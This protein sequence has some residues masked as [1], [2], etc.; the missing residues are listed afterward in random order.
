MSVREFTGQAVA[1]ALA[2]NWIGLPAIQAQTEV[3][4]Q[5]VTRVAEE[6]LSDWAYFAEIKLPEK[7]ESK[8]VDFLLAPH[9]FAGARTD[10]QD[11]RV[12]TADGKEVPFALRVRNDKDRKE[13]FEA[14]ELNRTQGPQGSSELTL[15]LLR[16]N[17]RHNELELELPGDEYRRKV[18]LEGSDDGSTWKPIH[19][20][21]AVSFERGD[22]LL[23]DK[24]IPYPPSRYRYL[25]IRVFQDPLVDEK[26]VRIGKV[27][28]I[29]RVQV[30]GE[31]QELQARIGRLEKG[32]DRGEYSSSWILHLQADRSPATR[33]EATIE[34]RDFVR[35]YRIEAGGLEGSNQKFRNIATGI[36]RRR[37]DDAVEPMVS[38]FNETRAARLRLTVIDNR[39]QPLRIKRVMYAAPARQIVIAAPPSGQ[40]LRLYY[41]NPE[42][43][44]PRYDFAR[45]LP[46]QL[47]PQPNRAQLGN[48][49]ENP[50]FVPAPL[51]LTERLPW[52]IYVVLGIAILVLGA[53]LANLSRAA[54]RAHDLAAATAE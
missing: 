51:P 46:D 27:A 9:V 11:L 36:W 5:E 38:R 24:S 19:N 47:D 28:V 18:E 7:I 20:Q 43:E 17:A 48:Q 33:L 25:R 22:V 14:R 2:C 6:Q 34:D 54:I 37:A 3:A 29:R 12:Y 21:F 39:N 42:A 8:W 45:N 16:S 32:R 15:D 53:I 1:L 52:L 41:G 4:S 49:V 35:N 30:P 23:R 44:N 50:I 26:P 31:Y 13:P 40:V 10:L